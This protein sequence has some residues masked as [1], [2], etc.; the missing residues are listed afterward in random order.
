MLIAELL[1]TTI[2]IVS[3]R[4][5][6]ASHV[7]LGVAGGLIC[8]GI[9]VR[10]ASTA[11]GAAAEQAQHV[12]TH[13]CAKEPVLAPHHFPI[14]VGDHARA[15]PATQITVAVADG[16]A[17]RISTAAAVPVDATVEL[18]VGDR[19]WIRAATRVIAEV[20]TPRVPPASLAAAV[21]VNATAGRSVRTPV[22]AWIPTHPTA[23]RAGG[24]ARRAKL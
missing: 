9:V 7:G 19:A 23:E 24:R 18:S 11:E 1:A 3:A 8:T 21:P 14:T 12:L 4:A 6:A 5:I 15:S 20:A 13:T 2:P 16:L 17:R 22:L 10:V